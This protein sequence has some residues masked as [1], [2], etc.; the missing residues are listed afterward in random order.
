MTDETKPT[1]PAASEGIPTGL[2][3]AQEARD[4]VER[5]LNVRRRCYPHWIKDGRLSRTEAADRMARMEAALVYL[6][7]LAN[8]QP[9]EPSGNGA[10]PY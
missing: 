1:A 3:T 4:E 9:S 5:E 7:R 2:S 10:H 6:D 8:L